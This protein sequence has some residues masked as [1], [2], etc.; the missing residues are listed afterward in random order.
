MSKTQKLP[1]MCYHKGSGQAYSRVRGKPIYFGKWGS[2]EAQERY[3]RFLVEFI[4]A[5]S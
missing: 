4:Q 2:E 1:K 5:G 3:D